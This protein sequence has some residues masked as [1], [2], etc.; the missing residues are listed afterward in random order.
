M[1]AMPRRIIVFIALTGFCSPFVYGQ[2]AEAPAAPAAKSKQSQLYELY[3][4]EKT[5]AEQ[6]KTDPAKAA[7]AQQAWVSA[8]KDPRREVIAVSS[9][10]A[11]DWLSKAGDDKAAYELLQN[12]FAKLAGRPEGWWVLAGQI[13]FLN[14][15]KKVG[16]AEALA[17]KYW[18]ESLRKG[19]DEVV[20][21]YVEMLESN[22]KHEQARLA[23]RDALLNGPLLLES[24]R[25]KKP[26]GLY[27]K[28]IAALQR[29]GKDDEA[30]SWAKL[31]WIQAPFNEAAIKSSTDA[32]TKVLLAGDLSGQK[33]QQFL[34]AQKDP[35]Q[36]NP[37]SKVPLPFTPDEITAALKATPER[38]NDLEKAHARLNLLLAGGFHREAMAFSRQVLIA[39]VGSPAGAEEICRVF[40][41]M[42]L[43]L[44][45]AN[46]FIAYLQKGEGENPVT[47]YFKKL[48][49]AKAE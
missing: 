10:H 45:R 5:L 20:R 7:V 11:S 32:L 14:R 6:I 16:E 40:K 43:N 13:G 27:Q 8:L 30:L 48:D 31:R 36:P 19:A 23:L 21:A 2:T 17:L 25:G 41:A 49:E 46:A 38:A 29:E 39:N 18:G 35:A 33:A 24:E 37:L 42:D 3:A 12:S 22:G 34:A 9:L 44:G 4:F 1:N 47:D 26:G 28:M 15:Q